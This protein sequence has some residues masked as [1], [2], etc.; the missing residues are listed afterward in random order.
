MAEI[1]TTEE[2]LIFI[3]QKC[4][5]AILSITWDQDANQLPNITLLEARERAKVGEVFHKDT[6][7]HLEPKSKKYADWMNFVHLLTMLYNTS[8]T[9]KKYTILRTGCYNNPA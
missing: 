7:L 5:E 8:R 9:N 1:E 4:K 6:I 2:E 3:K